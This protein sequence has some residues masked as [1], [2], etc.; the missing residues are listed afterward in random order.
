EAAA[1]C[2]NARLA[3][4]ALDRLAESTRPVGNDFALGIEGRCRALVTAGP[5]A[6][7]LYCEAIDRLTRTRRRPELARAYLLYGEWLRC[8]GRPREAR[9]RLRTAEAMF[10]EI[11]MQAFGDRARAE[12]VAAGGKPRMRNL[13]ARQDL[14]AQ[15]E[16]IARLARDGLTNAD[17]ARQLFLSP[18]TVEYHLHKVFGKLGIDSRSGLQAALPRQ[19]S[20]IQ[21][22]ST[23]RALGHRK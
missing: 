11:G 15:E 7:D 3:R 20:A 1:R 12:L 13:P 17:I 9:E 18:R 22:A 23:S 10:A 6:E 4:D 5:A 19:E 2:G 8:H 16:Q 21:R 14:T